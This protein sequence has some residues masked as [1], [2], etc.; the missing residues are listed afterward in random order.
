MLW[1]FVPEFGSLKNDEMLWS[2]WFICCAWIWFKTPVLREER[3]WYIQVS[4][5]LGLITLTEFNWKSEKRTGIYF[6]FK[7]YYSSVIGP[8]NNFTVMPCF[9]LFPVWC[10]SFPCL[11]VTLETR[12]KP[13]PEDLR[14]LDASYCTSTFE[15]YLGPFR[16]QAVVFQ[17]VISQ[18]LE[19][20]FIKKLIRFLKNTKADSS[21]VILVLFVVSKGFNFFCHDFDPNAIHMLKPL[22]EGRST[23]GKRLSE[24]TI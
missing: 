5:T 3:F 21:E 13:L 24:I 10:Q 18:K 17:S 6:F 16:P 19:T 11:F 23:V 4:N 20:E 15:I 8:I 9:C 22:A 12:S 2:V 1:L 7:T 14:G